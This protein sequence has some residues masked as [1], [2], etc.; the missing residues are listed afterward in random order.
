MGESLLELSAQ[1][2][3]HTEE[4]KS[5]E[6]V[7]FIFLNAIELLGVRFA[8]D[9]EKVVELIK[10][11]ATYGEINQLSGFTSTWSPWEMMPNES[12]S[13]PLRHAVSDAMMPVRVGGGYRYNG[14]HQQRPATFSPLRARPASAST[15]RLHEAMRSSRYPQ[16]PL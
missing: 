16:M 4:L 8:P 10:A 7:R 12:R 2:A 15:R 1:L 13:F 11:R 14:D 6:L 3:S 5:A 9:H